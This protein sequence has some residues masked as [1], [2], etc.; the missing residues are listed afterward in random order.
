MNQ[1][2]EMLD[3]FD[4]SSAVHAMKCLLPNQGLQPVCS[5]LYNYITAFTAEPQCTQ[6][7]S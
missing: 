2:V 4:Y 6:S 1:T 5:K 7:Q 3:S